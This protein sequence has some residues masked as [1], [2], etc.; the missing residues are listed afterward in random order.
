MEGCRCEGFPSVPKQRACVMHE[1]MLQAGI[2]ETPVHEAKSKNDLRK[3]LI[4]FV[5]SVVGEPNYSFTLTLKPVHGARRRLTKIVDAEQAMD[6]FLHVL[7]TRCF[8]HGYKKKKVEVGVVATLEGIAIGQHPH[9]HGVFRLP[10]GLSSEKF[11]F[12]FEHARKRT[13]R[14]GQQSHIEPYYEANWFEYITK[15]GAESLAPKF[16]RRGTL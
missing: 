15:L 9:W 7:N 6:W 11:L 5:R 14:L 16:M 8:G 3:A 1:S 13:R 10:N 4:E 12:A 2:D